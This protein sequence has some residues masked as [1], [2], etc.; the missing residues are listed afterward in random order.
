MESLKI[1]HPFRPVRLLPFVLVTALAVLAVLLLPPMSQPT[2]YHEFADRRALFGVPNFFDVASSVAFLLAGLAG[3][4]V[5][6]R[7]RTAFE[8]PAFEHPAF[9]HPIE[10][11][12]YAVFFAAVLLTA[13]GSAYYHLAPDNERLF[14]DRA[15][16]AVAFMALIAA[17]LVDRVDV[18][19]GLALLLPMLIAGVATVLYW[20]ASERTG[21]GDV[22]P[23][24]IL[25]GY[26][27][28]ALLLLALQPSRYTHGAHLFWVLFAYLAAKLMEH[29]DRELLAFGHV[30]SGHTLKH[31]TAAVG[32]FVVCRMLHARSVRPNR[33]ALT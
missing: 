25:Q 32:A 33:V 9:E 17:Q 12:P 24:A 18:R 21:A 26:G 15:A 23:Y 14:W 20:R 2:A 27:A 6:F 4:A 7:R 10:R 22:M 3:L 16:M 11:W 31:L 13:V 5:V 30:A 19:A 1:V 28:V 29:F 8:H